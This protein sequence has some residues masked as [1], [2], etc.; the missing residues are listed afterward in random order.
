M[1]IG[2]KIKL[3]EILLTWNEINQEPDNP[4]KK[5]KVDSIIDET[6]I[7]LTLTPPLYTNKHEYIGGTN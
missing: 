7:N 4:S 2:E 1:S 5:A 3:S 6:K